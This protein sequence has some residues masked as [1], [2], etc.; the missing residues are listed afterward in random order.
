MRTHRGVAPG[1]PL[2]GAGSGA[3]RSGGGNLRGVVGERI[4]QTLQLAAVAVLLG[5]VVVQWARFPQRYKDLE[6]EWEVLE[7]GNQYGEIL[8]Y[9]ELF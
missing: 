2:F 4:K 7:K 6:T 8:H 5:V 3:A 9:G 1:P